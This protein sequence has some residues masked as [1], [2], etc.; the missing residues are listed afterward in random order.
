[1]RSDASSKR[2]LTDRY[3]S[4]KAFPIPTECD[5]WPGNTNTTSV[6]SLCLLP[7]DE[8]CAWIFVLAAGPPVATACGGAGRRPMFLPGLP[9]VAFFF[10]G[11]P[12]PAAR[13]PLHQHVGVLTTQLMKCGEQL[14]ALAR[15][16]R[17]GLVVDE[18]LPLLQA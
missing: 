10:S 6:I 1:M 7:L 13:K 4:K 14:L 8:P 12:Q 16:E 9:G 18:G 11:F 17:G 15:A 2:V 5:P 3:A